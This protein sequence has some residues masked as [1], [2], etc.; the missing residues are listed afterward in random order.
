MNEPKEGF[1]YY[2]SD[3]QLRIFRSCSIEQRLQWLDEMQRFTFETA[4]EYAKKNWQRLRGKI[5]CR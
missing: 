1:F 4:P 3:E 5:D 2:V